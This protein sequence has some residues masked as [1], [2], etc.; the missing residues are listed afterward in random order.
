MNIPRAGE[1]NQL[2]KL[3]TNNRSWSV[4]IKIQP[5]RIHYKFNLYVENWLLWKPVAA[6]DLVFLLSLFIQE[7]MIK[8]HLGYMFLLAFV[9]WSSRPL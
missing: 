9:R 4:V 8:P 2:Q 3:L 1:R 6:G 7:A 5:R